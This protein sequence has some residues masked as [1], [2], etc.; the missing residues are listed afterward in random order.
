[1]DPCYIFKQHHI[2]GSQDS[3]LQGAGLSQMERRMDMSG[4]S[5]PRRQTILQCL[6]ELP[7]EE[8]G[9]EE[10]VPGR[11]RQL[12]DA[13]TVMNTTRFWFQVK[14]YCSFKDVDILFLQIDLLYY[15]QTFQ[16]EAWLPTQHI[17]Q[18]SLVREMQWFLRSKVTFRFLAFGISGVLRPGVVLFC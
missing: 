2:V 1:M 4:G 10:V 8:M 6:Q 5:H 13:M 15:R 17:T 7:R 11:T 14:F 3:S 18:D 16:L 9:E 12:T